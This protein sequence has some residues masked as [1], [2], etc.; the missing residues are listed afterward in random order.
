M[1]LKHSRLGLL[2]RAGGRS[3]NR[4]VLFKE[5]REP[6]LLW[7]LPIAVVVIPLVLVLVGVFLVALGVAITTVTLTYPIRA[8]ICFLWSGSAPNLWQEIK[9]IKE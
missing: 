7:Q 3:L 4:P 1:Q 9:E 2:L 5:Q 6:L 8:T